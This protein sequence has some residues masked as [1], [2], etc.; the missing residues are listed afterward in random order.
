M[1][2]SI[3]L[4]PDR[5][6]EHVAWV[7]RLAG[8]LIQEE[9]AADDAAQDSLFVALEKGPRDV[10]R[11]RPWLA[12]VVRSVVRRMRRAAER[13]DARERVAARPEALPAT[14][15]LVQRAELLRAV[16]GQVIALPEPYRSTILLRFFEERS[17]QEIAARCGEPVETVRTRLK[18]G[19]AI[20]REKLAKELDVATGAGTRA[21]GL[22]ALALLVEPARTMATTTMAATGSAAAVMTGGWAM[23]TFGKVTIGAAIVATAA[24]SWIAATQSGRKNRE[25]PSQ[26]DACVAAPARASA[27]STKSAGGASVAAQRTEAD[28]SSGAPPSTE[29]AIA[30]P[31]SES[32]EWSDVTAASWKHLVK[33]DDGAALRLACDGFQDETLDL[34]IFLQF[35][36]DSFGHSTVVPGTEEASRS[37]GRDSA[38]WI[39]VYVNSNRERSAASV[40]WSNTSAENVDSRGEEHVTIKIDIG[41]WA[42]EHAAQLGFK[43]AQLQPYLFV[44]LIRTEL[45]SV[46][47]GG[48]AKLDPGSGT[49]PATSEKLRELMLQKRLPSHARFSFHDGVGTHGWT[50]S[51]MDVPITVAEMDRVTALFDRFSKAGRGIFAAQSK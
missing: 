8:R 2:D 45:E 20:L 25:E 44:M 12:A 1:S 27:G 17:S 14:D 26:I 29:E 24:G 13:S 40:E 48:F 16:V 18:R 4:D 10:E 41:W 22:E 36:D 51:D 3:P 49:S 30:T 35:L 39:Q 37:G 33:E 23:T 5:L 42:A 38:K 50:R 7:R 6:L 32:S 9:A 19:L 47:H 28:R 31:S 11:P 15:D 46:F 43:P 21:R 34:A